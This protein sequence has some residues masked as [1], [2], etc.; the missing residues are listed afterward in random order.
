MQ[1]TLER[2]KHDVL[3]KLIIVFLGLLTAAVLFQSCTSHQTCAAYNKVEI[4]QQAK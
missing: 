4:D 1:Q 2:K 3:Q